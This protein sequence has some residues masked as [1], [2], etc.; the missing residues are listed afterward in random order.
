MS[1]SPAVHT[2]TD[3]PPKPSRR[4]PRRA[5]AETAPLGS[6]T[7]TRSGH[8]CSGCGS[9]QVTRLAMHLTDGTPVVFTSCH[10]CESRRWEHE[11][12]MLTVTDVIER[13]RKLG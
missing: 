13:T 6:L 9:A 10:R 12:E 7:Q 8:G 3:V 2:P 11:G 4:R 1:R 5:T